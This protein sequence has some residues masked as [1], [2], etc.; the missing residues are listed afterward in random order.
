[1]HKEAKQTEMSASVAEKGFLQAMQGDS[2]SCPSKPK[3]FKGFQQSIF[4]GQVREG[5]DRVCDQ[6]VHS[7]LF[8]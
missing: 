2:G 6:L 7:S 5:G 8:G 3:L 1:M 4:K